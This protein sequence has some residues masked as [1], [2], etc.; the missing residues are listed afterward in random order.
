MPGLQH[1]EVLKVVAQSPTDS[2]DPVASQHGAAAL[3]VDDTGKLPEFETT[4]LTAESY[5]HD[6]SQRSPWHDVRLRAHGGSVF[7]FVVEIS[8][9]TLCKN[10]V[11]LDEPWN[12][13]K[14]NARATKKLQ[15][16]NEP[17][18][19]NYGI[20]PQ[21]YCHPDD[22][23]ELD[24]GG[25]GAPMDVVELSGEPLIVG[26]V[27]EV[28]IVGAFCVI[29]KSELDWKVFTI[30][31]DVLAAWGLELGPLHLG[32]KLRRELAGA[33]QWFSAWYAFKSQG[34]SKV[35]EFPYGREVFPSTVALRRLY[36]AHEGWLKLLREPSGT[37]GFWLSMSSQRQLDVPPANRS[38]K[39]QIGTLS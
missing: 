1:L 31:S 36:R 39:A 30:R 16:F 38:K 29:D 14:D 8:N 11:A 34:S 12:P 10:E 15:A 4:G 26:H 18:P 20:F 19:F 23:M 3:Q 21:T 33:M 27:Y 9:G 22:K 2:W 7:N 6:P 37:P 17:V 13:I 35:T 24:I 25:D 5:M 28:E 32:A